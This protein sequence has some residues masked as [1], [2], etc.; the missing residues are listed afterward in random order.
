MRKKAGSRNESKT[1][2]APTAINRS[3]KQ[4]GHNSMRYKESERIGTVLGSNEFKCSLAIVCQP[5][6]ENSFPWLAGHANLYEKYK[7]HSLTY[8]YKNFKGTNA[9]GNILMNFDYDVTDP[10][11]ESAVEVSQSTVYRDGAP[12]RIMEMKVKTDGRKLF[13]RPGEVPNTDP[14]TYDMGTLFISTEGTDEKL[15]GYLEVDYDIEFFDKQPLALAEE[16][17][18]PVLLGNLVS[19]LSVTNTSNRNWTAGVVNSPFI[20][21]AV[22]VNEIGATNSGGTTWNVPA[23][24]YIVNASALLSDGNLTLLDVRVDGI[25]ADPPL[26]LTINGEVLGE[27]LNYTGFITLT[28][29][30]PAGITFVF[31]ATLAG[32]TAVAFGLR[33]L[34]Q[35]FTPFYSSRN[36]FPIG[37]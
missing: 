4:S 33:L 18:V 25:S 8:R 37:Q 13:T 17:F 31:S 3:A 14:K 2:Y 23:G 29:D 36:M 9:E 1:V 26:R 12:W 27:A 28:L 20:M 22:E 32:G 24:N 15:Q 11:P 10:P 5:G 34:L 30:N 6:L 35:K 7:V 16:P 19:C 21:D